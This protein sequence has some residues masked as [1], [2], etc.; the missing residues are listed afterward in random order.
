IAIAVHRGGLSPVASHGQL[1]AERIGQEWR[2]TT[3]R[4][5]RLV[6]GDL[7][8]AYVT[9]FYLSDQPLGLPLTLPYRLLTS[10]RFSSDPTADLPLADPNLAPWIDAARVKREGIALVCHAWTDG[11]L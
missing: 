9:A 7:E 2:A 6:G 3:P 1:L 10:P 8:L 11:R 4:P 5:L